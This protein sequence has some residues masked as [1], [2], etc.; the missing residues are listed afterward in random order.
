MHVITTNIIILLKHIIV[1]MNWYL[2]VQHIYSF[3]CCI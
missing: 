2:Q 3:Y 1:N